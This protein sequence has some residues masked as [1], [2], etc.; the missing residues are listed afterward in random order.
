[1]HHLEEAVLAASLSLPD[2]EA[3][4]LEELYVPHPPAG[5]AVPGVAD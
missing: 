5:I 1:M 2:D 3:R 4:R